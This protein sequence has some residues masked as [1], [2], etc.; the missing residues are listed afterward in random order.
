[1]AKNDL[2]AIQRDIERLRADLK[3]LVNTVRGDGL[4]ER[5]EQA[6]EKLVDITR[7]AEEEA[8]ERLSDAYDSAREY[9]G[10]AVECAREEVVTRPF[11][12]IL[13]SFAAGAILGLMLRRR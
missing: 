5:L 10:R 6:K 8:K 11:V 1:M 7:A 13:G 2:E 3:R 12:Y 4:H 9:S